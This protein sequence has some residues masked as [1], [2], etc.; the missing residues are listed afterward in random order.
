LPSISRSS[1]SSP[2]ISSSPGPVHSRLTLA[3]RQD[4]GLLEALGDELVEVE[5]AAV[6]RKAGGVRSR[7]SEEVVHDPRETFHLLADDV[8]RVP[9]LPFGPPAAPEGHV[10]RGAGDGHGRPQLVGRVRHELPLLR[11]RALE[12]AKEIVERA[13]ELP[14]LSPGLGREAE[15][16]C[17][18]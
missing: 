12:A 14:Q 13:G 18:P 7:E 2:P 15:R 5:R 9:V 4:A 16:G 3:L 6:Q 8:E 1:A 17:A 11:E 10:D